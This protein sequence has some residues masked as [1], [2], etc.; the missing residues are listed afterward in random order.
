[1]SRITAGS[2]ANPLILQKLLFA[3]NLAFPA[4]IARTFH[5]QAMGVRRYFTRLI[6]ELFA[7]LKPSGIHGLAQPARVALGKST[8]A[9]P[10]VCAPKTRGPQIERRHRNES[11]RA[12]SKS[13]QQMK[14]PDFSTLK[15]PNIDFAKSLQA[16]DD[17]L[18]SY[19][20][21]FA[22]LA[23]KRVSVT[24]YA[25]ALSAK[26]PEDKQDPAH[27]VVNLLESPTAT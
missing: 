20:A 8:L 16:R 9:L 6:S 3:E 13:L 11:I 26:L 1:M 19:A 2:P 12:A 25:R 15:A 22:F 5:P 17:V 7:E 27:V 24:D 4:G 10:Y 18:E 21:H 23:S 14:L